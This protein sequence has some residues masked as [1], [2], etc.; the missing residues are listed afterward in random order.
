MSNCVQTLIEN[1]KQEH[2]T[3]IARLTSQYEAER[4]A[5]VEIT[6][7]RDLLDGKYTALQR[8]RCIPYCRCKGD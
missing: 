1:I 7:D 6:A 4:Q 2:K 5:R 3:A 8:V